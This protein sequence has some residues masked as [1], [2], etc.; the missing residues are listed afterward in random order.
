[1]SQGQGCVAGHRRD[2]RRGH[3]TGARRRAGAMIAAA[4]SSGLQGAVS[5]AAGVPVAFFIGMISFFTPCILPLLP[6]YLSY[7]SGV[8]GEEVE[9]GTQRRRVLAGTLLFMLGFAIMF[10]ALG[11]GLA[12]ITGSFGFLLSKTAERVAGAFVVV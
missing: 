1:R 3:A 5:G 6:G 12:S 11:Y 9:M 7:V 4:A 10:T 2:A 8:S